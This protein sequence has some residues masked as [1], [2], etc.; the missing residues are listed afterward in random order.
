VRRRSYAGPADIDLLQQFTARQ[1]AQHG[2]VG[3]VHPGDIPHRIFNGLRRDDPYELIHIWEAEGVVVAWTLLDPAHAG[4]DPQVAPGAR[5]V[6]PDLEQQVI[7]WSEKMLLALMEDRGSEA[8]FIETDAFE[9]D[10]SRT[11]LLRGLGWEAQD[12][13]E[14]MLTRRSLRRVDAP[15]LPSGYRIR[16]VR[17]VEE[18]ARVA[19]LHSAGFGSDWTPELYR[20]VMESPGY[21]P[22]REFLVVAPDGALAGFCVTWVDEINRTGYFE[23]VA[24]HPDH[25][26]LGLGRALLRAGMIAMQAWGMEWAEVM[27]AVDNPGSG[28]LYRGEGFE[29]RWK[30]VLYRKLISPGS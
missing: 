2:R 11:E 26:L 27:Y 25:R 20:R 9:D 1:T 17:G 16:T 19:A 15:D 21:D 24:V 30:I 4:F 5:E 13:E 10:V 6:W 29:P 7:T 3:L 8:S 12:I 22:N 23:P 18:A 14:L 28:K